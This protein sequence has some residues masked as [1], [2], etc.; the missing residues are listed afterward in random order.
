M[1]KVENITR[2]LI[3]G[4]WFL[5]P[6]MIWQQ[7]PSWFQ[8]ILPVITPVINHPHSDM[9]NGQRESHYHMDT[10]FFQQQVCT[11]LSY[12]DAA[13][14][15]L[16]ED[17][18]KQYQFYNKDRVFPFDKCTLH[19]IALPVVQLKFEMI[20]TVTFIKN[21]KLKHDCIH[22][23]KCPHRGYDLSQV[24]PVNGIITC[25]LHGLQFDANTNKIVNHG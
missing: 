10:R 6:C 22:N 11:K 17:F 18:K 19:Y 21:S 20:T 13:I 3:T 1:E 9:E 8:T 12:K 7:Y 14:I 25:P 4:E 23:G 5:V 24:E 2:P 15:S 16:I